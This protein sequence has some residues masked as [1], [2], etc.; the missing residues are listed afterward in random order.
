MARLT[1]GELSALARKNSTFSSA[2]RGRRES[3]G[4]STYCCPERERMANP[5]LAWLASEWH[6]K[7]DEPSLQKMLDH[8][9]EIHTPPPP[10]VCHWCG[11]TDTE[12]EDDGYGP[13]VDIRIR[14]AEGEEGDSNLVR[15]ACNQH[16]EEATK[17]LVDA[18]FGIHAHGGI[19]FLEVMD[20]P[21]VN[22]DCPT[23]ESQWKE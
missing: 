7:Q 1:Y 2:R 4:P 3:D 8:I 10:N 11:K 21:G 23:P 22:G 15:F 16:L 19:C 18:G 17:T 14:V 6:R 12:N 9:R 13:L 5:Y 20:C